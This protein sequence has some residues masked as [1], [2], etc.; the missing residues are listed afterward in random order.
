MKTPYA[1]FT[2]VDGRGLEWGEGN[3]V[4]RRRFSSKLTKNLPCPI[5]Q[6]IEGGG[7]DMLVK[8][9]LAP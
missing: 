1:Y 7:G 8:N 9:G 5:P 4:A 3:T 6:Q 2:R